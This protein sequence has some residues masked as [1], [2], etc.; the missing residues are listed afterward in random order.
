M[1]RTEERSSCNCDVFRPDCVEKAIADF[2]CDTVFSTEKVIYQ[3]IDNYGLI[4]FVLYEVVIG[5]EKF[6]YKY[7]RKLRFFCCYTYYDLS[8][9]IL[10]YYVKL[11]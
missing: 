5:E 10:Y 3:P 1:F 11:T 8:Q 7:L 6:I 2:W 9:L 4:L